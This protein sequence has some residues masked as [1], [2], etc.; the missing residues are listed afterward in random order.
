MC[1]IHWIKLKAMKRIS[2][3]CRELAS[4][5]RARLRLWS[6]Y[7]SYNK[8][9]YVFRMTL[10]LTALYLVE[11]LRSET[12]LL[13]SPELGKTFFLLLL[14]LLFILIVLY[15]IRL[16]KGKKG[17]FLLIFLERA[18]FRSFILESIF[19]FL[20]ASSTLIL[21]VSPGSKEKCEPVALQLREEELIFENLR[22]RKANLAEGQTLG[23]LRK[24]VESA[25]QVDSTGGKFELIKQMEKC[26]CLNLKN[27]QRLVKYFLK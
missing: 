14:L 24:E 2:K 3:F 5:W 20:G 9:N 1:F 13:S 16:S 25:L 26:L 27:L 22:V 12:A 18:L 15:R 21:N 19:A 10:S 6:H 17:F 7:T 11:Y 4:K 23:Q 8:V